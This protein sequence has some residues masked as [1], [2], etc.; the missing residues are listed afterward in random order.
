MNPYASGEGSFPE[1]NYVNITCIYP[2]SGANPCSQWRIEPSGTYTAPDQTIQKRN[3][4]VL[5]EGD[6]REAKCGAS[7]STR[8]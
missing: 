8:R 6:R 2:T 5:R 1:T 3:V 7:C 4:A